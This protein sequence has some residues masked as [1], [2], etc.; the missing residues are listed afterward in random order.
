MV[1]GYSS[2]SRGGNWSP[3]VCPV[4]AAGAVQGCNLR[5]EL[6]EFGFPAAAESSPL[7]FPSESTSLQ[8]CSQLEAPSHGPSLW[9]GKGKTPSVA[10]KGRWAGRACAVGS[11]VL[12]LLAVAGSTQSWQPRLD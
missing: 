7:K 2:I 4:S 10:W 1:L 3:S 11:E 5:S 12:W 9:V 6:G 8:C